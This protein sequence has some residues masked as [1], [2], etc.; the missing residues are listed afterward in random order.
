MPEGASI[1]LPEMEGDLDAAALKHTEDVQLLKALE[2]LKAQVE[3]KAEP[4]Q[5]K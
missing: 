1:L 5:G 2:V 4:V 3:G